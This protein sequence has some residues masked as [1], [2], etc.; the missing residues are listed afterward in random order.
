MCGAGIVTA[1]LAW[2]GFTPSAT[3]GTTLNESWNGSAWTEVGDLNTSRT[4]TSGSGTQTDALTY[5]G[6]NPGGRLTATEEWDGTAWTETSD[7]STARDD[8]ANT[9]CTTIA[10]AILWWKHS[11][12]NCS[13]RRI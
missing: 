5:A 3:A 8:A 1:G 4:D 9:Q 6:R 2:S 7:V 12:C 11:K 13:N 10:N